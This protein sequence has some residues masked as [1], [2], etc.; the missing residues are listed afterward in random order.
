MALAAPGHDRKREL[1]FRHSGPALCQNASAVGLYEALCDVQ[2]QTQAT[3]RARTRSSRSVVAHKELR[4][5]FAGD[6]PASVRDQDT[7]LV[8]HRANVDLDRRF[9]VRV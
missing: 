7:N 8:L 6:T 1:E 3:G 9:G 2:P 5:L 4:H